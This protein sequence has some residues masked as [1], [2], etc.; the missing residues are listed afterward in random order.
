LSFTDL[1]RDLQA[2]PAAAVLP[3]IAAV[4]FD[5]KKFEQAPI[6]EWAMKQLPLALD[7]CEADRK[8]AEAAQNERAL[9]Y[10]AWL[11]SRRN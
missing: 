1:A 8:R 6:C 10:N 9:L 4:N 7:R 2:D 5:P 3:V 11:A